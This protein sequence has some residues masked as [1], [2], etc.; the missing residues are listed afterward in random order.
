MKLLLCDSAKVKVVADRLTY[1]AAWIHS[2]HN[3]L[4]CSHHIAAQVKFKTPA[5]LKPCRLLH[6]KM[7]IEQGANTLVIGLYLTEVTF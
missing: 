6:L 3:D 7:H 1:K 2:I 4:Q 5:V